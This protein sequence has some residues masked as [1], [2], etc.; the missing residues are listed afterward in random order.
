M[1]RTKS[2]PALFGVAASTTL[3]AA[4]SSATD[5]ARN[6]ANRLSADEAGAIASAF[7]AQM[8]GAVGGA[9]HLAGIPASL[10][11]SRAPTAPASAADGLPRLVL[12]PVSF[13]EACPLG[14]SVTGTATFTE[15]LDERGSGTITSTITS[16][17]QGCVVSAGD[18]NVAVTGAPAIAMAIA[19]PVAAFAQSGIATVRISGG[20]SWS[21]GSCQLDYTASVAPAGTGSVSGTVCGQSINRA[22]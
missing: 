2:R 6:P 1:L 11:F 20:F 15:N 22:F 18:R 3:A 7:V 13:S 12:S 8:Y 21:G 14:G 5:P 10:A 19:I 9:T 16:T 4:C 17:P